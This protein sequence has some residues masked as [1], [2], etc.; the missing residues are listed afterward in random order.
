M[1]AITRAQI[2]EQT[3]KLIVGV[4]GTNYK[5]K[6]TEWSQFL[7]SGTM[8][9]GEETSVLMT[10]LGYAGLVAEGQ[11]FS[12]DSMQEG[13]KSR[14][15]ALKYGLG[16]S[17]TEEAVDDGLWIKMAPRAGIEL[18]KALR[19]TKELNA[20]NLLNF[21][22]SS[23]HKGGDGVPLLSTVHPTVGGF[24]Q[25]NTLAIP[26]QIT[27]SAIEQM[28]TQIALAEDDRGQIIGLQPMKIIAH[29]SQRFNLARI[30]QSV[31]RQ[32]TTDNDI[33]ALKALDVFAA[34]PVFVTRLSNTNA[35]F[36]KTDATDGIQL[37]QRKAA[38]PRFTVDF[39]TGAVKTIVSERYAVNWEDWRSLYG[40]LP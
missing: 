19:K 27:E 23:S 30:L 35:W 29:P 36:I 8:D 25:S 7:D 5:E 37:R 24:L 31:Q 32:G 20:A 12:Y 18:E 3:Q 17:I 14:F 22:T 1:A 6:P 26:S 13:H 40:C 4:F 10:G 21:A 34:M 9:R 16:I 2:A 28:V 33:N 39:E 11:N 38:K 15:V